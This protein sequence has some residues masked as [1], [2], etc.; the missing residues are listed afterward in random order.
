MS[1]MLKRSALI[2]LLTF[3]VYA[4]SLDNPFHYD[5]IHSIV[6]NPHLRELGR[7]PSYFTDPTAFSHN[8][9]NAMYRPLL[10]IGFALN[11]AFGG[12]DVF[13]YHLVSIV[14]HLAC[15]LL[16]G[17]ISA[18]LCRNQQ[19][20]WF[21]AALFA[22]HPVHSEPVNYISSR[23]EIQAAFFVLLGSTAYLR[24]GPW[25]GLW[26]CLAFGAGL[27]SKSI[28]IVLPVL[29][30]AHGLCMRATWPKSDRSLFG[31][32]ATLSVLYLL[33][34]R[35]MVLRAT[36]GDPVRP[37]SEQIWTQVKAIVF[38]IKLLL[39]PSGLSV[40]HQFLIS[41]T[42]FDPYAFTAACFL[43]SL[44]W[45]AYRYR[46]RHGVAV[47][48]LAWFFITLAPASLVPLNVLV[49]E[50]RLYLPG[51]ALVLVTAY[52][53]LALRVKIGERWAT[54]LGL[55]VVV[56]GSW[57]TVQRNEVWRDEYAL[58]GDAAAKGPLMARPSIYL[59]GAY[60]RDGRV[61]EA[62]AALERAL[63]LDPHFSSGYVQLGELYLERRMVDQAVAAVEQGL[64][65]DAKNAGLWG[66]RAELHRA[67]GEWAQS[68]A[69]YE[70]AVDLQPA[71]PA[72]RNNL[73]NTYQ[74]FGRAME[75]LV[76]H[77]R[78]LA[79]VPG[80]PETLLNMGNA[81]EMDGQYSQ[82]IERYRRALAER[83]DFA[84][85]WFNMGLVYEK[86]HQIENA[87]AAYAKAVQLDP[88]YAAQVATRRR[89]IRQG[90]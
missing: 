29:L 46:H 54:G 66:L 3:A 7:I 86:I 50:H 49:N 89:A 24:D 45:W 72:L 81:F 57:A 44:I 4:N 33:V 62:I 23:S 35:S 67:R 69:A 34:V 43:A 20:G 38:Y 22:I 76:Q 47:F 16:V 53:W 41:D 21:A 42:L 77:Q 51:T 12:Y 52:A 70:R 18:Q 75:A 13:G 26:V 88:T 5:D 48:A 28:A 31:V 80:D 73:G 78:A 2:G 55:A 79:L 68:L 71:D 83:G 8:P 63:R 9:D 32:L 37:Y 74:V 61:E 19:A 82:A 30:L 27:L 39:W 90:P 1:N 11:Y 17:A 64:E 59:A 60:D 40:D 84:G 6:D 56:A 87:L 14:L 15:A 25:R 65:V 10:L 85:A 58:W 36:V